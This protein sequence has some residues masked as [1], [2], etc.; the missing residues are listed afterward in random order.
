MGKKKYKVY[1]DLLV[2][3]EVN[4]NVDPNGIDSQDF[5]TEVANTV[6][7]RM[8][9]EGLSFISEAI[10]NWEEDETVKLRTY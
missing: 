8:E 1:V 7:H 9:E 2:T 4:D 5:D 3:V 6:R 10:S